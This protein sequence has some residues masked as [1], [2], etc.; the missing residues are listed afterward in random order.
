[1][2]IIK[3]LTI[4]DTELFFFSNLSALNW[5]LQSIQLLI[6]HNLSKNLAIGFLKMLVVFC[7]QTKN[8]LFVLLIHSV[9][10]QLPNNN[11]TFFCND[12]YNISCT[13]PCPFM[14]CW[15]LVEYELMVS[16]QFFITVV[17]YSCC[18]FLVHFS[19]SCFGE[20]LS[21]GHHFQHW[22]LL[23]FYPSLYRFSLTCHSTTI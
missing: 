10:L 16:F 17:V 19:T 11:N 15:F 23:R 9:F 3:I 5:L 13:Y 18:I 20:L 6:P 2:F 8:E 21:R 1:M 7:G 22:F 14:Y 4:K 12:Q